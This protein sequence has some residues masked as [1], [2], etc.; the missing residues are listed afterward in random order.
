MKKNIFFVQSYLK[1]DFF[2][3]MS[4]FGIKCPAYLTCLSGWTYLF[5]QQGIP[6]QSPDYYR[7]KKLEAQ[8]GTH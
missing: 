1:R 5:R 4:F 3:E 2:D 7:I 8:Y 6:F